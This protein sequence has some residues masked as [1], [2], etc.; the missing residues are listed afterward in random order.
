MNRLPPYLLLLLFS[1]YLNMARAQKDALTGRWEWNKYQNSDTA[2]T[3]QLHVG[4][5]EKNILYPCQIRVKTGAT[6]FSYNILLA[7][8]SI[9]KIGIGNHAYESNGNG[10]PKL[11]ENFAGYLDL[12]RDLKGEPELTLQRLKPASALSI[13][14]QVISRDEYRIYNALS[15]DNINLK[16]TSDSAWISYLTYN[17]LNANPDSPYYGIHDSIFLNSRNISANFNFNRKTGNGI[18]SLMLNGSPVAELINLRESRPV[19]D[20]RL[21]TGLNIIV[22]FTDQFGKKTTST[23]KLGIKTDKGEIFLDHNEDK[24]ADASFIALRLFYRSDKLTPEESSI[25]RE[26]YERLNSPD[27]LTSHPELLYRDSLGKYI[28]PRQRTQSDIELLQ[29]NNKEAGTVSV[30]ARQITLAIWDDAV[31]DGDTISLRINDKWVVQNMAVKKKPQFLTVSVN[32]G[33]NTI[34]FIAENLGAIIP[35]TSVLEIND[36]RQRRAF[37]IDTNLSTNNHVN[38]IYDPGGN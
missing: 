36:G 1:G 21:D 26:Y 20:I 5:P 34:T 18:V 4:I 12:H 27:N 24:D 19:E 32:P 8:K 25:Q 30:K 29:R 11:M 35:N 33:P 31:E 38:I 9:R 28:P 6:T 14:D 22:L 17:I 2:L 16:K 10:N 3:F 23:G 37:F 13:K 15:T 7:R